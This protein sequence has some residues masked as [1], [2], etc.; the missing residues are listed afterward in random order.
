MA[1]HGADSHEWDQL[2]YQCTTAEWLQASD[3]VYQMLRRCRDKVPVAVTLALFGGYRDD[4]PESVL[5]L[6]AMD[7]ARCLEILNDVKV[8]YAAEVRAR[9]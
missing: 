7:T 5:G 1:A 9:G 2:G 6:H 4:H 8:E 3:M